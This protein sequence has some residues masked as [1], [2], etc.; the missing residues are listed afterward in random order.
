LSGPAHSGNTTT[1]ECHKRRLIVH[2]RGDTLSTDPIS[3]ESETLNEIVPADRSFATC[4]TSP[5]K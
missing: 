4:G 1:I 3:V 5:K 2:Q